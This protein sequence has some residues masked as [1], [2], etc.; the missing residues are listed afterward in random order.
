MANKSKKTKKK[1]WYSHQ[2]E[3]IG[4]LNPAVNLEVQRHHI[5]TIN[6]EY[7]M[8]NRFIETVGKNEAYRIAKENI[9]LKAAEELMSKVNITFSE[10]K[11]FAEGKTV[12]KAI[13]K[14]IVE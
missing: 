9:M 7:T 11:R 4:S 14:M 10:D 12:F 1:D 2:R 13:V 3:I 6:F 5:E 8:D